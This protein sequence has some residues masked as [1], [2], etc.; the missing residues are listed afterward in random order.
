LYV[1]AAL[2]ALI[3]IVFLPNTCNC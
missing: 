2:V 3:C 1:L